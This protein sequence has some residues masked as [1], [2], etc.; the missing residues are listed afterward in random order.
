MR[1]SSKSSSGASAARRAHES[2]RHA[3]RGP[4]SGVR[5]AASIARRAAANC[6]PCGLGGRL[7]AGANPMSEPVRTASGIGYAEWSTYH[8]PG[9][10]RGLMDW[11]ERGTG[12]GG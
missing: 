3:K 7:R 6:R 2:A 9:Q 8:E 1:K 4:A 10:V 12:F 11:P 5:P